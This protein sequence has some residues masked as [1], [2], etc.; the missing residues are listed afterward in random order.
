MASGV[1]G[2]TWT[3]IRIDTNV[4]II[5]KLIVERGI[6]QEESKKVPNLR[7]GHKRRRQ[8]IRDMIS[9]R[10]VE[11]KFE[12]ERLVDLNEQIRSVGEPIFIDNEFI[13]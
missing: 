12:I 6:L 4:E 13:K 10:L 5:D 9:L 3:D 7:G 8:V 1:D 11:I 2:R